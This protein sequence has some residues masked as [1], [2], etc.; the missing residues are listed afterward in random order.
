MRLRPARVEHARALQHMTLAVECHDLVGAVAALQRDRRLES[1]PGLR[2][3]DR[4]IGAGSVRRAR[5]SGRRWSR[6]SSSRT[7]S[8]CC[9]S[10]GPP[11]SGRTEACPSTVARTRGSSHPGWA[12]E[13]RTAAPRLAVL[14]EVG[15]LPESDQHVA[16][17]QQLRVALTAD[18]DAGQRVLRGQGHGPGRRV[19]VQDQAPR[20][21]IRG[22]EARRSEAAAA[23]VEHADLAVG[24]QLD[25]VLPLEGGIRR[26]RRTCSPCRRASR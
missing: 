16:V 25:V 22:Q 23:V 12:A 14:G 4:Q 21:P 9:P 1:V 6:R 18:R 13:P 19:D 15:L 8:S 26:A 10:S 5:A 2:G 17:R 7:R 24:L 20:R 3:D 11:R